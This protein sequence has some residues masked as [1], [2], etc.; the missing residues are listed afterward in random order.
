MEV[1]GIRS[2]LRPLPL[3]GSGRRNVLQLGPVAK[4]RVL[5]GKGRGSLISIHLARNSAR[6]T[7]KKKLSLYDSAF[8]IQTD[9]N[10]KP[11][12]F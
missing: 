10:K 5:S 8:L 2:G 3:F 7:A 11:R 9:A 12:L 6:Q 4:G 1:Y